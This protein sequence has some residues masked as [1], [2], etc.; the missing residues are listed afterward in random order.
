MKTLDFEQMEQVNGGL[1]M[2][3]VCEGVAGLGALG[4]LLGGTMGP[5]GT[6]VY[7]AF[8]AGAVYC[9]VESAQNNCA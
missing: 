2:C 4:L 3:A 7:A 1:N 6:G 5:I 9:T 8:C